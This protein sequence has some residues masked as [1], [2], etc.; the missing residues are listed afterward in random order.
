MKTILEETITKTDEFG[1]IVDTQTGTIAIDRHG[2]FHVGVFG[3]VHLFKNE[4]QAKAKFYSLLTEVQDKPFGNAFNLN[5][6]YR[7]VP[8]TIPDEDIDNVT[9]HKTRQSAY[10]F[11][12]PI[13][14][15][16]LLSA[17]RDVENIKTAMKNLEESLNG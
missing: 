16:K 15:M 5:G 9:Y 1:V 3:K 10:D 7:I 11:I 14:K 4:F 6:V 13:M 12:M 8:V 17:E 2:N